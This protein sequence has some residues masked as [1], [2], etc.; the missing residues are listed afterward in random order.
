MKEYRVP[1]INRK[2]SR[3][4]KAG[5]EV[6]SGTSIRPASKSV[7]DNESE[8]MLEASEDS[9]THCISEVGGSALKAGEVPV[10][11]CQLE[12]REHNAQHAGEAVM[13]VCQISHGVE[14]GPKADEGNLSKPENLIVT[15]L[16]VTEATSDRNDKGRSL[17]SSLRTGK[18]SA[19]RR[20]AVNTVS[21]Q[22]EGLSG[23][24][25]IGFILN[26]Q[27]KLYRWSRENPDRVY[28]DLFNLVCDRRSLWLAWNQICRNQGSRTPGIDGLNRRH[29]EALPGGVGQFIEEVY[30]Q[31]R[32]GTYTPQPVRQ[33]LIPKVGKPGKF[34]PLG[35]RRVSRPSA[36]HLCR[37]T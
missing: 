17:R 34:R 24:M 19:R 6:T 18:P 21:R 3:L 30:L 33:K 35:R 15:P 32:N 28:S 7:M 20:E 14:S 31:L 25:N 36:Q 4:G 13:P 27:R 12:T 37:Q 11:S 23:P 5:E 8:R 1:A 10:S 2:M 22:E 9:I 16:R 26:M 29:I